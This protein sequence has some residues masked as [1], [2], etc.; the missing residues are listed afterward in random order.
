MRP[1]VHQSIRL[2]VRY[3]FIKIIVA[4]TSVPP[5]SLPHPLPHPRIL[6]V[7]PHLGRQHSR[8]NE[9]FPV[10]MAIKYLTMAIEPLNLATI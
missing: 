5:L 10:A 1:S 3:A 4:A 6:Y 8:H 9:L 2:S 7:H